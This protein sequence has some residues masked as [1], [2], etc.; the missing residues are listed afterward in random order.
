MQLVTK[1][2]GEDG[3]KDIVLIHGTGA[4]AE[5]WRRQIDPLVERGYRCIVPDL[6]GHGESPEPGGRTDLEEHLA[7]M[8]ETLSGLNLHFPAPFAGHSLGSIISVELAARKPEFFSTI[9]AVSM[10]GKVP[11]VTTQAFKLLLSTPYEKIRDTALHRN[12]DWRNRVLLSTDKHALEEIMI[13]FAA[14][15]Y[16]E[17]LPE[18][19]CP[20]HFAVG[21]LDMVAPLIYVEM[22]HKILPGSTLKVI[23]WAGHNCMDSQPEAFNNWF[24]KKL[25]ASEQLLVR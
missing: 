3:G 14:L 2:F 23:E 16:A 8:T 20:V 10:P 17:R 12:L 4:R 15:N 25:E 18:V 9:L 6:R 13:N 1:I 21:R 19:R 11:K 5:M 7:D 24:F 22:M